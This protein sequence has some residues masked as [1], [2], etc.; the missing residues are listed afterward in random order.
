MMRWVTLEQAADKRLQP[1]SGFRQLPLCTLRGK[2]TEDVVS[3][4]LQRL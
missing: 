4:F 1:E 3:S 2:V